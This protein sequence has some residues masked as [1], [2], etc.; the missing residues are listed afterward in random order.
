MTTDLRTAL[1]EYLTLRRGLGFSL[2]R[3]EKLLLQ[4]LDYLD[5][6]GHAAF[7]VDDAS[8]VVSAP[9]T[10]AGLVRRSAAYRVQEDGEGVRGRRPS[11]RRGQRRRSGP[12][13]SRWRAGTSAPARR[14]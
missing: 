7:T 12:A 8:A 11:P 1:S 9:V 2:G 6:L 14:I 3:D 4:F 10:T 5:E 13:R